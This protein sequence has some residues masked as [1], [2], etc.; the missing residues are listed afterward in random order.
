VV[1][2]AGLAAL[3]AEP[4]AAAAAE[5]GPPFLVEFDS[6]A[7][8]NPG[9]LHY[10]FHY[11]D[12]IPIDASSGHYFG[13]VQAVFES[14]TG[15]GE[16]A[17]GQC[18]SL[19]ETLTGTK[20]QPIAVDAFNGFVN[21]GESPSIAIHVTPPSETYHDQTGCG[22]TDS[23]RT[24]WN[25]AFSGT[26]LGSVDRSNG[27]YVFPLQNREGP[28]IAENTFSGTAPGGFSDSTTIRVLATT[29]CGKKE[30]VGSISFSEGEAPPVG[31]PVCEGD[32][33]KTGADAR[34]SVTFKDGSIMRIGP[35]SEAKAEGV[36]EAQKTKITLHLILGIVWA[37]VTGVLGGDNFEV[38]TDRASSGTRARRFLLGPVQRFRIPAGSSFTA[39]AQPGGNALFHAV[40]GEIETTANG[41]SLVAQAGHGVEVGQRGLVSTDRWPDADRA[42]VPGGERPPTITG[43]KVAVA[44]HGGNGRRRT[45][46]TL[47]LD[48]PATLEVTVRKGR[49]VVLRQAAKGHKGLDAIALKKAFAPGRY[50]VEVEAADSAG[51]VAVATAK[52]MLTGLRVTA[53]TVTRSQVP[54]SG[55]KRSSGSGG[56]G[57]WRPACRFHRLPQQRPGRC[58]SREWR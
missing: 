16:A 34:A 23:E 11:T 8:A 47:R 5:T 15:G 58:P 12:K 24:F 21:P 20:P 36:F 44:K 17:A 10:S 41:K 35:G 29:P 25:A 51:R 45:K 46:A 32:T 56:F 3:G 40:A 26:H 22:A 55:A 52:L 6:H 27:N 42:L 9:F 43:L 53:A 4:G 49:K 54:L 28:V 39:D 14:A 50:G 13:Q 18:G 30:Q 31:Q 48:G 38:T 2:I 33:I 57:R 19:V 37:K 1:A 7:E